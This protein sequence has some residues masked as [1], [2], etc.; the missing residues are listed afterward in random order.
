[1]ISRIIDYRLQFNAFTQYTLFGQTRPTAQPN[2]D[3]NSLDEVPTTRDEEND[4]EENQRTTFLSQS[5]HGS[6]RHLLNLAQNA[7]CLVSEFGRPTLFITFT[8][9]PNW[10]EIKEMLF[11][12]ET[13]YDRADITTKVFHEKLDRFLQNMRSGKYFGHRHKPTYELRVINQT[14]CKERCVRFRGQ[15]K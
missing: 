1:M 14:N 2:N 4:G 15:V 5:F 9:N 8:C 3:I 7:I 12:G 6:R 11:E 13:A 10:P